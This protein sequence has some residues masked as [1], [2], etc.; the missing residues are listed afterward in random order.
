MSKTTTITLP[1]QAWYLGCAGLI[2]FLGLPICVLLDVLSYSLAA[3]YFTLYSAIILSFLGGVLWFSSLLEKN[4]EHM[5]FIAMLPSIIGWLSLIT[6]PVNLT[7]PVLSLSFVGLIFYEQKFL[8]IPESMVTQYTRLRW[9]LTIV[10]T[11]AHFVMTL[12]D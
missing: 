4:T 6:L 8:L 9:A 7:I 10:V 3:H 11:F 2:P 1:R 5:I 12:V